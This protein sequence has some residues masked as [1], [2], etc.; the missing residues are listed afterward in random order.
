MNAL[1]VRL[2]K[3]YLALMPVVP[4][5]YY[6]NPKPFERSE[7]EYA[8]ELYGDS[9]LSHFE[10]DLR[11]LRILDLGCGF[12]GRTVRFKELGAASVAGVEIATDTV[13]EAL[14]FAEHKSCSIEALTGVAEALP[15]DDDRFDAVFSYDVFEHVTHLRTALS[16]CYRVLRPGGT[17]YAVFPPVHHPTGGSHFHGY[18]SRSPSPELLFSPA[19]LMAAAELIMEERQQTLRPR[20]E[21]GQY[22][23][24]VNGATVSSVRRDLR[25]I[26]FARKSVRLRPLRSRRWRALNPV[27]AIASRLP[28]LQE[29]TTSR[30]ICELTK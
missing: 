26:P 5:E 30:I 11:G 28:V 13:R 7:M 23:P 20:I 21:K 12:G 17:L 9:F 29:V 16:E 10:L 25:D 27:L 19:T 1:S 3:R 22:L 6:S 4:A 15:F 2:A 18:L 8:D 24:S 14:A